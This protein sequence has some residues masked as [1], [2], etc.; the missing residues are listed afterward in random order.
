VDSEDRRFLDA[1]LERHVK[2]T[3]AMIGAMHEISH[4]LHELQAEIADQ[5]EQIQA[6]TAVLLKVLD[7]FEESGGSGPAAPA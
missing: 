7:R 1:F 5:R 4:S 6:N 2:V 3:D